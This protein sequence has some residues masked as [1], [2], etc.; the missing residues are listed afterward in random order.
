[1]EK[2]TYPTVFVDVDMFYKSG[3]H[4]LHQVWREMSVTDTIF[5]RLELAVA[6]NFYIKNESW[7]NTDL[8]YLSVTEATRFSLSSHLACAQ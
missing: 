8:Q 1:M 3:N 7:S 6:D 5:G 4:F 2:C